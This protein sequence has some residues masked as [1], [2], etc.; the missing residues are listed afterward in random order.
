MIKHI[1]EVIPW[2]DRIISVT[3][4]A[5]MPVTF[6][7]AYAVPARRPGQPQQ[8][9]D[10]E[11]YVFY[12]SLQQVFDKFNQHGPTHILGDMNARPEQ[13]NNQKESHIVGPFTFDKTTC[14]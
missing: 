14:T 10:A 5:A 1:I 2:T 12:D 8:E 6:I 4:K 7:G 9:T 3:L 11:K 13:C